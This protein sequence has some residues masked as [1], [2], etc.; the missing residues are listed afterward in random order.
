M[1]NDRQGLQIS[2]PV[3]EAEKLQWHSYTGTRGAAASRSIPGLYLLTLLVLLLPGKGAQGWTAATC[4]G[5]AAAGSS[6]LS[7]GKRGGAVMALRWKG[8]RSPNVGEGF[9]DTC[10]LHLILLFNYK[11]SAVHL[12]PLLEEGPV[13]SCYVYWLCVIHDDAST[14]ATKLRIFCFS[15]CQG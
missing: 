14:I 13:C 4:S 7:A 1:P 12:Q 5:R 11:R 8:S 3:D 10:W 9:L 2:N 6:M 15:G